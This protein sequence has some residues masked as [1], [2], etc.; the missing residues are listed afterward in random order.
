[1]GVIMKRVPPIPHVPEP[2]KVRKFTDEEVYQIRLRY[3][4]GESKS[5]LA[6]AYEVS[7][8]TISNV[9]HGLLTYKDV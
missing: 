7:R 9:I 2:Q 5:S 1:M 8:V 3:M 4:D 6:R